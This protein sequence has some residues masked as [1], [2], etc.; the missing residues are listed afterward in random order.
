MSKGNKKQQTGPEGPTKGVIELTEEQRKEISTGAIEIELT[1][2]QLKNVSKVYGLGK[3]LITKEIQEITNKAF[4]RPLGKKD[5]KG[6]EKEEELGLVAKWETADMEFLVKDGDLIKLNTQSP[7]VGVNQGKS[8]LW[9]LALVE[10]QQFKNVIKKAQAT[11]T[12]KEY[13]MG[14]GYTEEEYERGGNF[15]THWINVLRS[16][17]ITNY[18][19][20]YGK[21]VLYGSLYNL[22]KPHKNKGTF[23]M[24]FNAFYSEN[25]EKILM[26]GYKG[27][28]FTHFL[29]E[30]A[31]R[32]T[33]EKPLLHFFYNQLVYRRRSGK[34]SSMPARI[35]NIL[36][37]MGVSKKMR[38][39]ESFKILKDCLV[40]FGT[41]YPEE[42]EAIKLYNAFRKDQ[43]K[44][45]TLKDLPGLEKIEYEDF[46]ETLKEIGV[47]DIR[48]AFI[49]FIRPL[50]EKL[51]PARISNSLPEGEEEM[52]KTILEWATQQNINLDDMEKLSKAGTK[53]FLEDYIAKIGIEKLKNR[54]GVE[55]EKAKPNFFDFL[56]TIAEDMKEIKS[57]KEGLNEIR[58]LLKDWKR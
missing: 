11:F 54:L 17:N 37:E 46:K 23:I 21:G 13:I 36:L 28:Y 40:Y 33:T 16:G 14:M 20:K 15:I 3:V 45:I 10:Q 39:K 8:I 4:K 27:Q 25:I 31:D 9:L 6:K 58:D 44:E 48:E 55:N 42:L 1:K 5:Y 49:S 52:I 41:N 19:T 51:L 7:Q 26:S 50:E 38:P 43:R 47:K 22:V 24:G 34:I 2:E 53:K 18:R 29:K 12:T 57:T 35:K 32:K 56:K 30:I